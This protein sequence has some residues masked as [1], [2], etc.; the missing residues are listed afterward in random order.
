MANTISWGKSYCDSWWGDE[1]NKLSVLE[2]SSDCPFSRALYDYIERI[3]AD[4]GTYE[5]SICL[6]TIA[7][8]L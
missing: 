1:V 6:T 8:D 7:G 3:E 2:W 4:G 5:G